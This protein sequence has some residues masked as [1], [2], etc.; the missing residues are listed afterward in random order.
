MPMHLRTPMPSLEGVT[1][2]INGEPDLETS[3]GKPLLVYFW[4]TSCHICHDNMPILQTWREKY[5]PKGLHMI[6]IHCPRMKSDTDLNKVK[7]AI[8]ECG[9]VESCGIDN[10]HKAKKAFDNDLWP[11]YFIFDEEHKLKR[12]AAGKAG[13]AMLEPIL[14]KMFE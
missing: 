4:A 7:A 3:E 2:W 11:A 1:E 10:M 14:E 12:R 8:E 5:I 13:L 6:A 9:V